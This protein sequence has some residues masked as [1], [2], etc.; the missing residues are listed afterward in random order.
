[1]T[2]TVA[3]E[4]VNHPAANAIRQ[5]A[6]QFAP[7]LPVGADVEQVAA[8]VFLEVQRVPLLAKCTEASIVAAASKL[9]Q[10][11]FDIG[12]TGYL[13][14]FKDSKSGTSVATPVPG[15]KGFIELV[16]ASGAARDCDAREVR[17]GDFF[18]YQFGTEGFLRHVP[19][20]KNPRQ[21][22][23]ITHFYA[24]WHIKFGYAKFDVMSLDEV[25]DIRLRHSRQWG[26]DKWA[27]GE[28]EPWYGVKTVIRR[29]AKQLPQNPKLARFFSALQAD[30]VEELGERVVSGA[31][32]AEPDDRPN[33]AGIPAAEFEVIEETPAPPP[34]PPFTLPNWRG[35]PLAGKTLAACDT[36]A[37]QHLY[38]ELSAARDLKGPSKE[39]LDRIAIELDERRAAA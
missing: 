12:R 2:T 30:E 33:A 14:P 13:V 29:S 27:R 36:G 3:L 20:A 9:V 6:P 26:A 28:C 1:M 8:A 34:P 11:G 19:G 23:R 39:A 21:R 5:A 22:G 17:E 32:G 10:W 15:Y 38:K 24:C 4:R 16:T 25:E 35:H 31:K 37:L 18:E 7:F